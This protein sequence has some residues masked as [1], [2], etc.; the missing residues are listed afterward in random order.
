MPLLRLPVAALLS[1]A[2]LCVTAS[3]AAADPPWS[4]PT[5]VPGVGNGP[6][7]ATAR[8]H[9]A[10]LTISDRNRAPSTASQL[11]RL[12][13]ADG[14]VAAST[15]IDLAGA[16]IAP[17]ATDAIAVAG[18]SI[19]PSGTID[20]QSRVRA[21][22]TSAAGG[23]P[24]LRTLSGT[25][26]QNV[27][28]LVGNTRDDVALSTRGLRSRLVFL[29]R[30][31]TSTFSRVLTINV[32]STARDVTV[33]LS[34][35]GQ[36]LVVWEDRHEVLARRRGARGT[37]GAVHT[38]GPGIQSNLQA[39]M[40]Q[41]GRMLVAWKSQRVNEGES[42]A[43]AVVSY[44]TAASGHGFGT[45]R[46]IETV[47]TTG[48]GR[49]VGAPGVRLSVTTRDQALLAWTGFDGAHFV[50]RAAPLSQGHVGAR[51]QLSPGGVDAVLG[52]VATANDG[53]AVV[54]WRSNV[55]GAAR[56][57]GTQP[58]LFG[59]VGAAAARG[60]GGPEAIGGDARVVLNPP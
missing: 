36:L 30:K 40:D 41:T 42:S 20:D 45:R 18:S 1:A 35:D 32:S 24:A 60:F 34:P 21:G 7:A 58:H 56:V 38:L 55:A 23:T 10:A 28:A 8:G 43:A 54:L 29:R 52:D 27:T 15:G 4:V 44:I 22:T 12:N 39:A 57:T 13:P 14:A 46:T 31:G 47:G 26:S 3:V 6:A 25:Q 53:G 48:A 51:Q 17:Y 16:A 37:W 19:G 9:V 59:N 49:F 50:V 2:L 33:A 11:V 5:P